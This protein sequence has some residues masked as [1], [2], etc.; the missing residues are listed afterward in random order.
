MGYDDSINLRASML[1]DGV[2]N[3]VKGSVS[4]VFK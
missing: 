3:N 4:L 1:V 2:E